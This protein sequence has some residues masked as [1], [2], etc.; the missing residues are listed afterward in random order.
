MK[1][2]GERSGGGSTSA[3]EV[4]G[5]ATPKVEQVSPEMLRLFRTYTFP[6]GKSR[7]TTGDT[8][9]QLFYD[10]NYGN[11][12]IA[13][14]ASH[15]ALYPG[16]SAAPEVIA[17]RHQ[18]V[19]FR[20]LAAVSHLGPAIAS[21]VVLAEAGRGPQWKSDAARLLKGIEE[22]RSVNSVEL[23]TSRLQ[24]PPI[25]G[26]ERLVAQM[27]AYAC[28]VT[29]RYLK[30]ALA[31]PGYLNRQTLI[32]DLLGGEPSEALPISFNKI[33]IATFALV[34]ANNSHRLISWFD[35]VDL[36]WE[37]TSA[38][39]IGRTGPPTAGLTKNTNS[40]ARIFLMASRGRLPDQQVFMVPHAPTFEPP[41]GGDLS[42]VIALEDPLRW[43]LARVVAGVE[44]APLMY[45]G[46]PEFLP[47]PHVGP[48]IE[49]DDRTV[50]EM[51]RIK[52]PDDWDTMFIR[53]R[54]SLED[55]RQLQASGVTDYMAEQL[56]QHDNDPSRIIIPGL[57]GVEY[58]DVL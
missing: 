51:P 42:A 1:S 28:N 3:Q 17:F 33:M 11:P 58:P 19:A 29:T 27:I 38:M 50:T 16:N 8:L 15:I 31:E 46:Y 35:K 5:E 25:Q 34:G 2:G 45:P 4:K 52:S 9:S 18:S 12:L 57:D 55:P 56:I 14:T 20:E 54:L 21:L 37:R 53:M 22:V 6:A 47:P 36:P 24:T 30:R 32:E 23:W 10:R 26:R 41:E 43:M 39:L 40:L 7:D 44:L 48:D 49:P 13:S